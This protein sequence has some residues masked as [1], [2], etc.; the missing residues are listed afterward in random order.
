MRVDVDIDV[1]GWYGDV[2]NRTPGIF[3]LRYT[4]GITP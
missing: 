1:D 2:Y 3:A 4:V